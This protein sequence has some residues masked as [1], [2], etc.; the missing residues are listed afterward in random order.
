MSSWPVSLNLIAAGIKPIVFAGIL[1][2][3]LFPSAAGPFFLPRI[4]SGEENAPHNSRR[5]KS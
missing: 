5:G 3:K 1:H 4:Q 2:W